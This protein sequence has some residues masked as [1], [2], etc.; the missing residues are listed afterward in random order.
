VLPGQ[1]PVEGIEGEGQIS[2]VRDLGIGEEVA[3]AENRQ[4]CRRCLTVRLAELGHNTQSGRTV[5]IGIGLFY[6]FAG[7]QQ[8]E[9]GLSPTLARGFDDCGDVGAASFDWHHRASHQEEHRHPVETSGHRVVGEVG[10]VDSRE[11]IERQLARRVDH[12]VVAHRDAVFSEHGLEASGTHD[13][14]LVDERIEAEQQPT[15]VV[16][17]GVEQ[18]DLCF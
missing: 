8:G 6:R 10:Q 18:G 16:Q 4:P 13:T 15:A 1:Q 7:K 5:G 2:G 12:Q 11:V 17:V 9:V 3:V 14:G